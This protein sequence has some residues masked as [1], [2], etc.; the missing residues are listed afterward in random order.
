MKTDEQY[1]CST[2][3]RDIN[4]STI[5]SWCKAGWE[6][7][8]PV[9][10][11][12]YA[13][14]KRGIWDVYLTPSKPVPR[15]WLG[16]LS[17][18]R[19]LGLASG[20]GQQIPIFA[21]LGAQCT[22]FDYSEVQCATE[23][24]VAEREGYTVEIIRA[25]MAER[26]PFED[27]SFDIIF[28]PVSNCYVEEA[29]PVFRE[30]YR[31]LRNGGRLLCGLDNGINFIL[32]STQT[33]IVNK[34]PF[35]PLKDEVLYERS[36]RNNE[37]IQFSHTAEEQI[38]GQLRAGFRLTDLYEDTDREGFLHDYNIPQYLATLSVKP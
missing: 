24:A 10:S 9:T 12:V 36:V 17:G 1:M 3:Y 16:E 20:G 31:V 6:W 30:C 19:L 33:S 37:G 11:E 15:D 26:L 4:A 29:E 8:K 18:K 34:L 2:N 23:R 27:G 32:D 25:D 7:G 35:N 21:A 28:N 5:D 22:M 14:A 13:R 38:G